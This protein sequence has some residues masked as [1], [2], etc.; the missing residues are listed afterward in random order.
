M[1]ITV[2]DIINT[3]PHPGNQTPRNN[4]TGLNRFHSG[5][6][7]RLKSG[8]C[9]VFFTTA[10]LL[11]IHAEASTNYVAHEW[12]TF[13]SVQGGDGNLLPWRPL[14]TS[15]LPG[16]VYNWRRAGMNRG[17][18]IGAK[19]DLITLQR[20]ETPV[21]YFYAEQPM[22]VAVDVA[23][24]NGFIT[25]WYPQA[26]QIGPT[27]A[28]DTNGPM[29]G[30]LHESRA[31]WKNLEIVPQS[32][33]YSWLEQRLPED[34]SGSHYFA[35]RQTAANMVRTDFNSTS[36]SAT[37]IEKFIFYRGAGS[38]KT[39]L[40][41]SVDSSNLVTV[42]NTGAYSLAHLFL[43]NIHDDYGAFGLMDE[44]GS[45]NSV[46]WLQ[47]TNG[48]AEHWNQF[49]LA[50]F[51]TEIGAQMETALISEGL[52]PDEA[53]AM[54]NTWKDSWFTEQGVRILY[55]LPR[56][57]TDEILP[58]ALTPRP[59]EFTRVMIGRAEIIT[60]QVQAN[61]SRLL[62]KAQEGDADARLHAEAELKTLG[63]FAEAARKLASPPQKF[64]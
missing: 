5:A 18:L 59:K 4:G 63:R 16:F 44:L 54:V 30:I 1:K 7:R 12:G 33:D 45:S 24:P 43:V 35:A 23:F 10:I 14:K 31:I 57:W 41:V 13:T 37:E 21:I 64:E 50:Q 61:L 22:N 53:I 17:P 42:E 34:S 25:E 52:F 38:F 26:A 47:L 32:K 48:P 27:F 36:N 8:L 6:M 62:A 15:E 58:I 11:P 55:I 3:R 29:G 51:R 9:A 60:P 39:P 19:G 49:P 20:L 46:V 56:P 28:M 40:H 2:S